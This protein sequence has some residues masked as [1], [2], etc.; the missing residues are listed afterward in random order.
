MWR[1]SIE[2]RL[3]SW[4]CVTI[5]LAALAFGL[6]CGRQGLSSWDQSYGYERYASLVLLLL[7]G[8]S[9]IVAAIAL[10]FARSRKLFWLGV[11]ALVVL[12]GATT[13]PKKLGPTAAAEMQPAGT[14]EH[15]AAAA[16]RNRSFT[17]VSCASSAA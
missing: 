13:Q 2:L 15:A 5:A 1:P 4:L 10:S 11:V 3:P 8:A 16:T 6:W 7:A 17:P 14:S 12:Y 9:F